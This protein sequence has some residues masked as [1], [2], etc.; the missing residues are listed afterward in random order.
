MGT[1]G[2]VARCQ[3]RRAAVAVIANRDDGG[4]AARYEDTDAV[5]D[6]GQFETRVVR[7]AAVKPQ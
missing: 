5:G 1:W 4:G 2:V 6:F 7:L 3:R